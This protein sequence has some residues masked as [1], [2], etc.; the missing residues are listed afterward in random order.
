LEWGLADQSRVARGTALSDN[1]KWQLLICEDYVG[2]YSYTISAYLPERL[3]R[4]LLRFDCL[5]PINPTP[6]T[7][8]SG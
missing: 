2:V 6:T 5:R 8:T 4:G 7:R 1:L 3:I